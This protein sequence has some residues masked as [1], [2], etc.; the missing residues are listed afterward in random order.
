MP[1]VRIPEKLEPFLS[2]KKRYKI[3]IGGRGSAKSMTFGI[4]ALMG[5]QTQAIKT[6]CF[7]E[8]Q[9][10]I[11]DSVHA[12]L[13]EQIRE[14]ELEG[15]DV[16]ASKILYNGE[17]AFKF[18]GLAR[19]PEGVKSSQGF[20]RFWIEEAQ[21]IS[22]ES[23]KNLAPTLRKEDSELWFSANPRSSA[24]PFSQRFIKPFE[25]QI[26]RDGYYEDDQHL[27]I[28]VNHSDN[29]FLPSVLEE[30]RLND[31]A[32]MKRALY[33]HVWEGRFYDEVQGSII[34]VDW[35]DAAIDAHL[36]IG[37]KAEGAVIASYDPSDLGPDSKGYSLRHGSIILD[38]CEKTDGDI[39][40]GTE[41]ALN[42]SI[43]AKADWFVWDADGMGV[44]IKP[45]VKSALEG[46]KM[47]YF[48]FKGSEKVE[49]GGEIYRDDTGK[50]RTNRDAFYNKRS[51]YYRRLRDKFYNTYRAVK[52]GEY[53]NPD[54]LI[55][56]SSNIKCI[57]E[58]RS[59]VCR[60]PK[61]PTASGKFQV[62]S[63][64]DM[65]K[66]PYEIPS[67]NMADAL[68]MGCYMPDTTGEVVEE[69]EFEGW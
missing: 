69:L 36:K 58:L 33:E 66:K 40:E 28:L 68:M 9:N 55:S 54:E 25:K 3:A 22:S 12:L 39:A 24:D 11:D 52:K 38:V 35:F 5:A 19:N 67:P 21:T 8:Y 57:D 50:T 61:K 47:S 20:S 16:Q 42:K 51:Q 37:F 32:I 29:P 15:F 4:L 48:M 23:L 10:S 34:P 7:R 31:K 45:Q 46:K 62:M 59:E 65:A 41:W 30:E 26:Y 44:A 64:L 18:R 63:K 43:D 6:M 56:L 2:K 53:V 17:D 13:S 27:I 49:R 60:I 14:L 1:D